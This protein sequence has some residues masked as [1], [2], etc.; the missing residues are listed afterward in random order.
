MAKV[1][2]KKEILTAEEQAQ[3]FMDTYPQGENLLHMNDKVFIAKLLKQYAGWHVKAAQAAALQLIY[4]QY[5]EEYCS[6]VDKEDFMNSYPTD[7]IK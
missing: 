4:E 3:K 2:T 6:L 1:T 5:G 7:K